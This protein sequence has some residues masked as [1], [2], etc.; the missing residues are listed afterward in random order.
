MARPAPSNTTAATN[1][2]ATTCRTAWAP[3]LQPPSP[4]RLIAGHRPQCA[5]YL[6]FAANGLDSGAV[7]LG[8]VSASAY[9]ETPDTGA[10]FPGTNPNVGQGLFILPQGRSGYDALQVVAQERKAHPYRPGTA[11]TSRPPTRFRA[12]SPTGPINTLAEPGLGQRQS[13]LLYGTHQPG[14]HRRVE[15][16][17]KRGHQGRPSN[18]PHRPLLLCASNQS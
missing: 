2:I 7:L 17:R 18:G 5:D 8:G 14:P 3:R 16:R 1:A 12:S 13:E 11:A 9:G 10:A 15:L 6:N 4:N